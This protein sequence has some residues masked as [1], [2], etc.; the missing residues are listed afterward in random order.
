[1]LVVFLLTSLLNVNTQLHNT[2]VLLNY[3]TPPPD[4]VIANYL[5]S[6]T[7]HPYISEEHFCRTVML[8]ELFCKR[9]HLALSFLFVV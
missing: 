9:S 6:G 8:S 4:H 5:T 2:N 1:M 3:I 7:F